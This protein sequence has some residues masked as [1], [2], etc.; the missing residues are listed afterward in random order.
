[1]ADARVSLL[2]TITHLI[3]SAARQEELGVR[4]DPQIGRSISKALDL[5]SSR[6]PQ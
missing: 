1:M 2:C 3:H 4:L 6:G 5:D